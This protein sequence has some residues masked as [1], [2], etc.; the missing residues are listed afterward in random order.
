[1]TTWH[2]ETPEG[3]P[4]EPQSAMK[5]WHVT[6]FEKVLIQSDSSDRDGTILIRPLFSPQNMLETD[7][8]NQKELDWE[9]G[10]EYTIPLLGVDTNGQLACFVCNFNAPD[11]NMDEH[12]ELFIELACYIYSTLILGRINGEDRASSQMIDRLTLMKIACLEILPETIELEARED[13]Q[14]P[15]DET[16]KEIVSRVFQDVLSAC[17][18]AD[19]Y[20][21][22][23]ET[24]IGLLSENH[25]QFPL[26]LFEKGQRYRAERVRK[27][28]IS[29]IGNSNEETLNSFSPLPAPGVNHQAPLSAPRQERDR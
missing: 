18:I 28:Y 2:S 19:V 8:Y 29:N 3:N 1:M 7:T 13:W 16:K 21:T 15:A 25:K 23:R 14:G 20:R 11:G 5:T 26:E 27:L 10:V 22:D 9:P 24:F 17:H 12:P 6:D 4:T